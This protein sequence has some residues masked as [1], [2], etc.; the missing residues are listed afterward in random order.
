MF[1]TAHIIEENYYQLAQQDLLQC[2]EVFMNYIFQFITKKNFIVVLTDNQANVLQIVGGDYMLK[3]FQKDLNFIPGVKLS[4]DFVG[5]TAISMALNKNRPVQVCGDE[6][7]NKLHSILSCYAAP[8]TYEGEV[9][10]SLCI[11]EH[12]DQ[13]NNNTL[14]MVI[15][16]AK[17]IENQIDNRR[18][19]YKIAQ[20]SKYQNTIVENIKEGFLTI[21]N[22]GILTY[23]NQRAKEM[24]AFDGDTCVGKPIGEL[25]PFKPIILEVLET[26]KGY[27]DREYV[28]TNNKGQKM[29]LLKTAMPIRDQNGN[30]T[31]V[32]DIFREIEYIKKIVNKMVGAKA[33]FTFDDLIG[34]SEVFRTCI[35][36]AEK[37]AKSASNV[38]IQGESGTGKELFAHSIHN[39]SNRSKQPFVAINCAAIPKELIESELFGYAKGSFTGGLKGGR[40]GKFELANGGTI[41]LDEIGEMPIDVQS[42]LL[43]VLQDKRVTR[44]GGES[45]FDIDVRIIAATNKNLYEEAKNNNFRWDIYYRLNVLSISIPP[46]DQ[47][48][49]DISKIVE[50]LIIRINRR[51]GTEVTGVDE[52]VNQALTNHSWKGNVRELENVLERM[53]NHCTGKLI[54]Y[55]ILPKEMFEDDPLDSS[56]MPYMIQT[57]EEAEKEILGKAL[58]YFEGNIT[59]AAKSLKISRNTL[60]NKINKYEMIV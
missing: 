43:R 19:A 31:G 20:Q 46:L 17:G 35:D 7:E 15:A 25:V 36:N 32:I 2:S 56:D 1:N 28:L 55:D 49:E 53:M 48:R 16:S 27:V 5:N 44:V 33:N 24:L 30:L 37:A 59:K 58:K 42:K 47:R 8:I 22:N 51:L 21:D 12:N 10:G 11:T 9:L 4:T 40:P 45:I 41:F 14:G 60:Y 34:D 3:K 52:Q 57:F 6:H 26:G 23:I 38:L 13:F 18:R 29:H 50:A 54:T 39:R